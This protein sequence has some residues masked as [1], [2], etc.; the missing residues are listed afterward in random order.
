[1]AGGFPALDFYMAGMYNARMEDMYEGAEPPVDSHGDKVTL[2]DWE[3]FKSH[4]KLIFDDA[5]S[6]L[7]S[8]FPKEYNGKRME[9]S[10]LAYEDKD[11]YDIAAQKKALHEDGFIGNRLRGTVSL[12][13]TKTGELLDKKRITLMKLPYLTNRGT[14]IKDGNEWGSIAQTRL[15]PGAYARRQNNGDLEMQFNVRPGTGGAFRVNFNPESAQYKISIGGSD[16]HLYSLMRELGV[17]DEDMEARWGRDVLSLNADNYDSRVLDKAYNKLVP[18]W[19]RDKNPGRTRD[20][21]V[22]L[23]KNALNRSQMAVNVA[24]ATLPNMFDRSKAASWVED[25]EC[26]AKVASMTKADLE[27]IAE[28]AGAV[29]GEPV[30]V[31]APKDELVRQI[32]NIVSTGSVDGSTVNTEVPGVAAVRK[33]HMRRVL[34]MINS[35]IG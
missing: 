29:T 1:M 22:S 25:G 14:F 6:A 32:R 18:E 9:L 16:I 35:K 17:P 15:L 24:K 4:R 30:A 12:F 10:D 7:E 23:I 5:K 34:D 20:E 3:D 26:M 2:Y 8:Q 33:R 11:S 19:D 27:D 21:K 31:D 13:D 28:F